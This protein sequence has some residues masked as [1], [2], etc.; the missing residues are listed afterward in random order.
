M[1]DNFTAICEPT[2]LNVSQLYRPPRPVSCIAFY[3]SHTVTMANDGVKGLVSFYTQ[4]GTCK[5]GS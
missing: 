5:G 2:I 3:M 1:A 4:T